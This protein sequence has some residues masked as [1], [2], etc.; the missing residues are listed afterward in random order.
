MYERMTKQFK[1]L[2]K[3]SEDSHLHKHS[4]ECHNRELFGVDVSLINKYYGKPTTRLIIEAVK[5][6]GLPDENSFN[7]NL[8]PPNP[9]V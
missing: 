8:Y 1:E 4:Q 7:S 2:E 5:I 9:R 6:E 3:K